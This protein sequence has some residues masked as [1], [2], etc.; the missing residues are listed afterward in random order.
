MEEG[1]ERRRLSSLVGAL[2]AAMGGA[3][4]LCDEHGTSIVMVEWKWWNE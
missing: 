3:A 2:K 1:E 4:V